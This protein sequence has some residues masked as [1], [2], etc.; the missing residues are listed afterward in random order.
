MLRVA[1]LNY[2]SLSN[3]K[4][5]EQNIKKNQNNYWIVYSFFTDPPWSV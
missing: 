3:C 2:A 4:T 5:I 1:E